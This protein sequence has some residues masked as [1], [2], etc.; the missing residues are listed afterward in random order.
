MIEP[1]NHR[2]LRSESHK[3]NR[4]TAHRKRKGLLQQNL[5]IA[6][7]NKPTWPAGAPAFPATCTIVVL[8][9]DH[10]ETTTFELSNEQLEYLLAGSRYEIAV[11]DI[12][13]LTRDELRAA[14]S[15]RILHRQR[16]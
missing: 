6:S 9:T 5:S 8:G 2:P 4:I 12:G 11:K 15:I 16:A 3:S 13:R 14:A 10:F 1:P 7:I